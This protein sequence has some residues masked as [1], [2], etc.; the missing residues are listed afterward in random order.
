MGA[1][2]EYKN[3]QAN[4]PSDK[5]FD[6]NF[7]FYKPVVSKEGIEPQDIYEMNMQVKTTRRK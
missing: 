5:I 2:S 4:Q 6:P 1:T 3:S 7:T